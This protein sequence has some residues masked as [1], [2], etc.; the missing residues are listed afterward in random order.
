[1]IVIGMGRVGQGIRRCAERNGVGINCIDRESGWEALVTEPDGSVLVTT[2]AG[3]LVEVVGRVP[4]S[5]LADL[6]FIQN[7]MIDPV[8]DRLGL[9]EN[10]RG[11]LYFAVPRRGLDPQPGGDSIFAGLHADSMC[12]WFHSIE[13]GANAVSG[14]E[15][16]AEMMSKLIW[17]CVFGLL[18]D[19][20]QCSVGRLV[21]AHR[22]DID[23]LIGELARVSN[24]A[25][26]TRL[27]K[28]QVSAALCAYSMSIPD[29][30]GTL[31]QWIWRNGW[32][33]E[34]SAA[35]ALQIPLHAELL[36]RVGATEPT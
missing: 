2:N 22:S 10:T 7:G 35:H 24:T 12:N 23:A 17:N 20:H 33:V 18:C 15:F 26:G 19:V 28:E 16:Q 14:A 21:E 36:G 25:V 11:L 27:S 13:L 4:S 31:K 9:S 8:L 1:M 5:R 29:Y 30:T 6:V 3:D 32:F 34:A